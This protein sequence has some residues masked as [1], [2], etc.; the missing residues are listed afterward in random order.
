MSDYTNSD[1][2]VTTAAVWLACFFL[3]DALK[4]PVMVTAIVLTNYGLI[5]YGMLETAIP[6]LEFINS[7]AKKLDWEFG[8]AGSALQQRKPC[9]YMQN[10]SEPFLEGVT[11]MALT[12]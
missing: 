6:S 8:K 12:S 3:P 7:K 4:I 10:S 9:S 2:F 1:S 5:L 11:I